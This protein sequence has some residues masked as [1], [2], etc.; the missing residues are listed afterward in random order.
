MTADVQIEMEIWDGPLSKREQCPDAT[1]V[2]L[3]EALLQLDG[4]RMDAVWIK[5]KEVGALCIGGGPEGFI[6]VS[7]PS[8]GSSSHVVS[9]DEE[10]PTV[11]LQV[12]GQIGLYPAT[13]VLP[14]TDAFEIAERFLILGTY[15]PARRWIEDCP[16]E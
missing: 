10:S 2:K 12:G 11:E 4:Q 7:F 13:M 15:D 1:P 9:S 8:D 16:A 5:V 3:R 6:V 14:A